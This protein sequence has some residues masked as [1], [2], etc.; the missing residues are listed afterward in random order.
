[1]RGRH[2]VLNGFGAKTNIDQ[3]KD[4]IAVGYGVT[5][6]CHGADTSKPDQVADLVSSSASALGN[7]DILVNNAGIQHVAPIETFPAEKWDQILA[8]DLSGAFHAMRVAI[9][10]MKAKKWG[11]IINIAS[12]HGLVASPFKSAYVAAKHGIVGLTKVAALEPAEQRR[13]GQ[14][15]LPRLRLDAVGRETDWGSG[16][17][18]RHLYRRRRARRVARQTGHKTVRYSRG[19]CRVGR[20]SV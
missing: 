14:C 5:V 17:G 10:I 6:A 13:D 15:R 3:T 8:I 9:P 19:A 4:E 18:A 7:I 2:I 12:A 1:L 16:E 11:R 20:V